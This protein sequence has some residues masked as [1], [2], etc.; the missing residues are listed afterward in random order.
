MLFSTMTPRR[1]SKSIR[2]THCTEAILIQFTPSC[3]A[4]RGKT[5]LVASRP[6]TTRR[7]FASLIFVFGAAAAA[8]PGHLVLGEKRGLDFLIGD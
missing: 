2:D 1:F 8:V 6:R 5:H 4:L 7:L 3:I